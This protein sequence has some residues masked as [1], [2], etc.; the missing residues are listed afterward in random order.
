M[1][2]ILHFALFCCSLLNNAINT[3][4]DPTLPRNIISINKILLGADSIGVIPKLKPTVASAET[5]SKVACSSD[6]LGSNVVKIIKNMLIA[7]IAIIKA[8][9]ALFT[10]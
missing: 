5:I 7:P 1:Y 4:I 3:V 2:C 10:I 9:S 6:K 8:V